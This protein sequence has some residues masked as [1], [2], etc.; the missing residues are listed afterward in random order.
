MTSTAPV[1]NHQY[2]NSR[3]LAY[4]DGGLYC[5]SLKNWLFSGLCPITSVLQDQSSIDQLTALA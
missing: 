1:V 2:P 4:A 3:Y 5:S